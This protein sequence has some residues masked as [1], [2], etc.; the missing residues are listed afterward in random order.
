M[1]ELKDVKPGD[2]IKLTHPT[3]KVKENLW[4]GT[5]GEILEVTDFY[6]RPA[7]KIKVI[8]MNPECKE[9]TELHIGKIS[10]FTID[11]NGWEFELVNTDWDE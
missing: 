3:V 9:A 5:I 4:L 8:R 7:I 2:I 10:T 11:K 1:T 6:S